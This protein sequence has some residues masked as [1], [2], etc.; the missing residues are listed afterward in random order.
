MGDWGGLS[1]KN[2]IDCRYT[3]APC[4]RRF[5]DNVQP[6]AKTLTILPVAAKTLK[7]FGSGHGGLLSP[8]RQGPTERTQGASGRAGLD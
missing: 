6:C 8:R 2:T 7:G 3:L 1:V 4:G 5:R